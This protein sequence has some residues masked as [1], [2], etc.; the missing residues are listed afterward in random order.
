MISRDKQPLVVM[1]AGP[2]GGGKTTAALKMLQG[3]LAVQEF[4]NAD[5]IARGLSA[6]HPESVAVTAGRIMLKRLRELAEGRSD[7][8]FETTLA[9]RN[10][11]PWLN[12]L[13]TNGYHVHL[14]FVSLTSPDLALARVADRVRLGGHDI[15]EDVVRRRFVAGITNFFQLYRGIVDDW[16]MYDNSTR[17]AGPVLIASGGRDDR[18]D[19][20]DTGAWEHLIAWQK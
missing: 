11:A 2:N 16:Q 3:P 9:G 12:G 20:L 8:A 4:V 19:I 14:I 6:F 1:I 10:F 15:P 7:F 13:R 18:L 5:T 17:V